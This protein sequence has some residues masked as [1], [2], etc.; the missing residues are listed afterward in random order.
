LFVYVATTNLAYRNKQG[1]INHE[2]QNEWKKKPVNFKGS[3]STSQAHRQSKVVDSWIDEKTAMAAACSPSKNAGKRNS[4]IEFDE[5]HS[6]SDEQ[7]FAV[8][9]KKFSKYVKFAFTRHMIN[10]VT[11]MFNWIQFFW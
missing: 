3:A 8:Q 11:I 2:V 1:A 5:G 6:I 10:G 4:G 9:Y 7:L